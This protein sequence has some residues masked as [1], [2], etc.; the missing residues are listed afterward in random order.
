MN[1]KSSP[2]MSQQNSQSALWKIPNQI[3]W[4]ESWLL[5]WVLKI[6]RDAETHNTN[7]CECY[8]THHTLCM[9]L[10]ETSS[11]RML[12]SMNFGTLPPTPKNI[13]WTG[14]LCCCCLKSVA[15]I[16]SFT[17]IP[18]LWLFFW[19][20]NQWLQGIY[21]FFHVT[22]NLSMYISVNFVGHN[23]DYLYKFISNE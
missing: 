11:N 4:K 23:V 14:E 19:G 12:H 10:L 18:K 21:N 3:W 8:S 13:F 9:L 5:N 16:F 15:L 17:L 6:S 22:S 2:L 1:R 7:F 20:I